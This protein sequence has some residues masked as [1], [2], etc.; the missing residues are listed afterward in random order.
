M[1]GLY[2]VATPIGNLEDLSPRARKAL[3][4]AHAVLCEDTRRTGELMA[5]LGLQNRLERLDA[6][7]SDSALENAL[8]RLQDGEALALVTD[9]GTPGI[10]D[11][12]AALVERAREAG[13]AVIPIAGPSAVTALLSVSGFVTTA[14]E[15][16]GFFPRQKS[17]QCAEIGRFIGLSEAKVG[18]W[19]ESPHRVTEALDRFAEL[20]PEARGIA[21]KEMTKIHERFFTGRAKD[22]SEKVKIEIAREGERG[23][24][25][26]A[27]QFD[28]QAADSEAS[29]KTLSWNRVLELLLENG[30]SVS[31][32]SRAVSQAFGVTKK[33]VYAE[34]L[35]KRPTGT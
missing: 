16:R 12:A 29:E 19:F 1:A 32:S 2:V 31:E 10:S 33:K 22:L 7:A 25:C 18:V 17:E 3:E 15:F 23:E 11:P 6:H 28:A 8:E 30:V 13:V 14:F 26:V 27:F 21:A 34:A 5:A 9:A 4:Q 24:W 35:K 20:A